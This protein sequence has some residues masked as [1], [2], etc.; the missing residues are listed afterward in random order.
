MLCLVASYHMRS[1]GTPRGHEPGCQKT[2][3]S[4]NIMV[5]LYNDPKTRPET[6]IHL[7]LAH[8]PNYQEKLTNRTF[9]VYQ[10]RPQNAPKHA[11]PFRNAYVCP[12]RIRTNYGH[13]GRPSS[14]ALRLRLWLPESGG[15]AHSLR[16]PSI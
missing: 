9:S 10:F 4:H 3:I 15:A 1:V 16:S 8:G 7:Q 2:D 13:S 14:A 5:D 6:C 11:Y 12:T